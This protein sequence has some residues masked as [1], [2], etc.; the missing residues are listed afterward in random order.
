[1]YT[2]RTGIAYIFDAN[3]LLGHGHAIIIIAKASRGS[4]H[5][6]GGDVN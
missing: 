5:S 4:S 6:L 3:A 2:S 1:M